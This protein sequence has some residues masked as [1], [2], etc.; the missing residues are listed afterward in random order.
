MDSIS[1]DSIPLARVVLDGL[2]G[3][4]LHSVTQQIISLEGGRRASFCVVWTRAKY[5]ECI[6]RPRLVA[7]FL[8]VQPSWFVRT[9]LRCS[10]GMFVDNRPSIS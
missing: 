4:C 2:D 1:R 10:E 6:A 5:P 3:L 8:N 9:P 7:F